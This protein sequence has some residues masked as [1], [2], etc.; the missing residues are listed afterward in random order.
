MAADQREEPPSRRSV[1]AGAGALAL[2]GCLPSVDG[3]PPRPDPD[4]RLRTRVAT[5]V[6]E[7]VSAYAAAAAA[8]PA[9]EQRLAPL[10]AEHRAHVAALRGPVADPATAAT[11]PS[12]PGPTSASPPPPVVPTSPAG[13]LEWLAGLERTAA[14][15]R[16]R[17]LLR[18][19]PDL[20]RLLASLAACETTHV[21]LLGDRA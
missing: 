14:D 18:A 17:Q 15:R 6:R 2:T 7:L 10:A 1:L 16:T 21:R 12:A 19:G 13:T 9:L 11:T 5:E 8:F 20:A 4:L 3:T